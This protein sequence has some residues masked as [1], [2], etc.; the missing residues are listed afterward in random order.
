MIPI[1]IQTRQGLLAVSKTLINVG[2][3]FNL[4]QAQLFWKI[5]FP[6][7]L[8]TIFDRFTLARFA[9][10]AAPSQQAIEPVEPGV[11]PR[12]LDGQGEAG[13]GGQDGGRAEGREPP[14][15]DGGPE[16]QEHVDALPGRFAP[17]AAHGGQSPGAATSG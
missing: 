6:A 12:D 13:G 9:G 15:D 7:A 16:R 11:Q 2:R 1:I 17:D 10:V 8:P 5:L 14:D 3:S 4:T